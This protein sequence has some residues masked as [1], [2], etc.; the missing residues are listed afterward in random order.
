MGDAKKSLS[1][2]SKQRLTM[3]FKGL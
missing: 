1:T 3:Y 2:E